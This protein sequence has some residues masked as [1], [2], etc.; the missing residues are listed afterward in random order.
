MAAIVDTTALWKTVVAS[1]IAGV[2]VTLIFSVAILG[3]ARF[4]DLNRDGRAVAAT[5]FGTLAI[6]ALVAC[7]GGIVL[8]VVVMTQK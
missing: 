4:V 8:G 3:I 2:G 6:L 5:A 1:L 7:V